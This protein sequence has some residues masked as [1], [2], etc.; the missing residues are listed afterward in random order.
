MK[1]KKVHRCPFLT[2]VVCWRGS[3]SGFVYNT[4]SYFSAFV[5]LSFSQVEKVASH[6]V[7]KECGQFVREF[8]GLLV[9]ASKGRRKYF[10]LLGL[11]KKLL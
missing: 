9:L 5:Y 11:N 2:V 8:L 1:E 7:R 6:C 3:R 10:Y 4:L